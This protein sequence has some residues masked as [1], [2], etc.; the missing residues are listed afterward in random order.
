MFPFCI[1]R[2]HCELIVFI[3]VGCDAS[4]PQQREVYCLRLALSPEVFDPMCPRFLFVDTIK[5][6][7]EDYDLRLPTLR[8]DGQNW[9]LTLRFPIGS[10]K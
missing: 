4:I 7:H 8:K 3:V 2:V 1:V 5:C 6:V 9:T 10:N